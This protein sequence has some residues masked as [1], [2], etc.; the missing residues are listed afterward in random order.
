VSA[1]V[2]AERGGVLGPH[3]DVHS[4]MSC[5]TGYLRLGRVEDPRARVNSGGSEKRSVV[6]GD[7]DL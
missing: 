7:I 5:A 1:V 4:H 3:R 6:M 2:S